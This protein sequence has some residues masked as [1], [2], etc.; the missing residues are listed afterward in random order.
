MKCF[1]HQERDAVGICSA[2]MRGVCTECAADLGRGLAC[3]GRCELE[4][5]RI[6][7]LRDFSFTQ[8][9]TQ[10]AILERGSRIMLGSGIFLLLMGVGMAV[11]SFFLPRAGFMILGIGVLLAVWEHFRRSAAGWRRVRSN[12]G[13]ARSAGTT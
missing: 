10:R 7:D 6:H 13:F 9:E 1:I 5:R 3:K 12:S 4:L 11:W 2:C 8:P